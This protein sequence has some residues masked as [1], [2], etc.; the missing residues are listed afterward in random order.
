MD[1]NEKV[2]SVVKK[3]NQLLIQQNS[4]SLFAS[5]KIPGSL[6][7]LIELN[8]Q[9]KTIS[10]PE[11]SDKT[12]V[13]VPTWL[14]KYNGK[15]FIYKRKMFKTKKI[16][17]EVNYKKNEI[18]LTEYDDKDMPN[19]Y[20]LGLTD[21][22]FVNKTSRN[23]LLAAKAFFNKNMVVVDIAVPKIGWRAKGTYTFSGDLVELGVIDLN[24]NKYYSKGA[25]VK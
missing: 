21:H 19:R 18:F 22:H 23:M 25:I 6:E 11:Y 24:G 12:Q 9:I 1:D 7:E 17:F 13:K 8:T 5:N 20:K 2:I 10:E 3:E 4:E 15:T 14:K 16:K